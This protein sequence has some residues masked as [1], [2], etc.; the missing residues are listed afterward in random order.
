MKGKKKV[1]F[2]SLRVGQV[3]WE[4]PNEHGYAWQFRLKKIKP[5]VKGEEKHNAK[6]GRIYFGFYQDDDDVLI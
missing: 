4:V 2:G 6:R 5:V 1:K 3:F